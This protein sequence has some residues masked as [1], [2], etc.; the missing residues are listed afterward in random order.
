MFDLYNTTLRSIVDDLLPQRTIRTRISPT[1]PWFDSECR[2]TR[3]AVRRAERQYKRTGLA[4]DR[5]R[6]IQL[7]RDKHS[8]FQTKEQRFWEDRIAHHSG[9][10]R[11]LWADLSSM[12]G[13]DTSVASPAFTAEEYVRYLDGKVA[14]V[15][16]AT[17][18]FPPPEY[19]TTQHRMSGF[20]P[21]TVSELRTLLL[22]SPSKTCA[23]DPVPTFLL[24]E[25]VDE[26]LP[27][28][29]LLC[30][31]SLLEG[32][33][34]SS[35][36][37]AIVRPH[38]KK[39]GLDLNDI[40]NFR[41]VSN[42]SFLSKII[43]KIVAL[44]AVSYLDTHDLMPKR[45][46]GFRKGHSTETLLLR[47]ISDI[48]DTMDAGRVT[49]LA[50]LDVSAAFD[51][52]DH[53][54]I[55]NRLHTSYGFSG[56]ALDWMR[57]FLDGREMRVEI[58]SDMSAW[59]K[60]LCGVPQGSVLGPL[61]Y[62]LYTADLTRVIA[63]LGALDHQYADD[64]QIYATCQPSE[65]H[66]CVSRILE[67]IDGI[68][69]WMS[70]NRLR[71]NAAKTQFIWLGSQRRLSHIDRTAIR[72]SFPN[73]DTL[74]V[75]RDL[76]VLLDEELTMANHVNTLCRTCFYE[77]RQ[78]R[79]IRRNL[80]HEAAITL[81]HSFIMTRLDYCNSI[82]VGLPLFRIRQL[83]SVL[84]CAARVVAN[85]SKFSHISAYMRDTLHWLPVDR[86][87]EFKLLLLSRASILRTAPDYISELFLPVS[88]CPGRRRLRSASHGQYMVS[89]SRTSTRAGRAFSSVGPSLWNN[90]PLYV[91][92]LASSV[93]QKTF[94]A[95]LKTHLFGRI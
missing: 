64:V 62:I 40:S 10:S 27:F 45:Q 50:L 76:G 48:Y 74:P 24:Q 1:T 19:T 32:H 11:R 39:P 31:T 28:L 68:Q 55:L 22:S 4:S 65:A 13:R 30:N 94:S 46:S 56:R 90:L 71:L 77:L 43:E 7:L 91:R 8:F 9:D 20:R 83:Q 87:I 12:L 47:L 33:L 6:W 35:E 21:V 88:G 18:G 63:A 41:P 70:S 26:L 61:L 49:L 78:I 42:L 15:R 69:T 73:F 59:V 72:A 29:L 85:L 81:V 67:T 82:L 93:I 36:K 79:V 37:R 92:S 16:R 44:Q 25:F 51:T 38:L 84:N 75:V 3:R 80:S 86:R 5:A 53:I 52:V 34:P 95:S 17:E 58:G 23:L 66:L 57:S 14:D 89:R 60:V 2:A 54:I